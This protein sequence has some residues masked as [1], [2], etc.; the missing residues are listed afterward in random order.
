MRKK[1]ATKKEKQSRKGGACVTVVHKPALL[2]SSSPNP[3][4]TGRAQALRF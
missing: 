2:R 4:N 3:S 1:C